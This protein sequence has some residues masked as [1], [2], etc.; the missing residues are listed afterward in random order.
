MEK[1]TYLCCLLDIYGALLTERQRALLEQQLYE[2][3]SLFEISEREGITRQAV[4]DALMRAER[5]LISA[6]EKIGFFS[7]SEQVKSAVRG[8]EQAAAPF[9]SKDEG[10][11]LAEKLNCLKELTEVGHGI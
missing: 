11:E 10:G 6:E 9:A 4:R 2:D 5:E 8:V 1:R 3:C 7:Y